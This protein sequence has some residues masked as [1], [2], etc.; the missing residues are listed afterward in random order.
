MS[1]DEISAQIQTYECSLVEITGGEPLMQEIA[2]N[3]LISLLLEDGYKVLLETNGSMSIE[4]IDYRVVNIIDLKCPDSGMSEHIYWEN[5]GCLSEYDQLKF[6][7]SSRRD[8]DWMRGVIEDNPLP[9]GLEILISVAFGK[10]KPGDV[11]KW[12]LGDRLNARFQ[13]QLHKY[14]WNPETRGV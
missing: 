3:Q 8:Y 7:L 14:I 5:V 13:L 6:V 10:V 9:Y 11:V 2:T 1:V 12:M 4:N